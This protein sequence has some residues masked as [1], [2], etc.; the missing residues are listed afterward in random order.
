MVYIYGIFKKKKISFMVYIYGIFKKKKK[1]HLWYTDQR[2]EYNI[3]RCKP[4]KKKN[5]KIPFMV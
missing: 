3:R 4:P 1:Y 2:F 5:K